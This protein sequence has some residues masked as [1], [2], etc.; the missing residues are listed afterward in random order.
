MLTEWKNGMVEGWE[1]KQ[2]KTGSFGQDLQDFQDQEK[3]T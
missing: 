3:P 2:P 1:A